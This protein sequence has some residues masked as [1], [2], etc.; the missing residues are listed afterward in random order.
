M[1]P[2]FEEQFKSAVVEA[3]QEDYKRLRENIGLS[4]SDTA[5]ALDMSLRQYQRYEA[6]KVTDLT[7]HFVTMYR[8]L[9]C[10]YKG[11]TSIGGGA[12]GTKIISHQGLNEI[13][14]KEIDE[15]AE[16]GAREFIDKAISKQK[17]KGFDTD[18][19]EQ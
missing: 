6:G 17:E 16:K 14:S 2:N 11:F 18:D 4:Q 19:N 9:K 5:D 3:A 8:L 10:Y 13:D 12:S 1:P 7:K 15:M